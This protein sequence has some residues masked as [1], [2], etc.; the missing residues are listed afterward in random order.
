MKKIFTLFAAIMMA[1]CAN[2]GEVELWSGS[3]TV[4]AWKNAL[5]IKIKRFF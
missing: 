4:N 1:V 3:A 5:S 2:A